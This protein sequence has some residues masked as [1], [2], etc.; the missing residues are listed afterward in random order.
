MTDLGTLSGDFSS[1]GEAIADN[2]EV[3]GLSCDMSGNCRAFLWQNGVM[4]DLNALISVSSPLFLIDVLGV[5]SRGEIVGD[6]LEISSGE[7]HA[8]L[9]TPRHGRAASEIAALAMRG[10][11]GKSPKVALPE[12][13][14]KALGKRLGRRYHIPLP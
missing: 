1:F 2:G 4:T 14:R 11:S 13:V 6:A 10:E 8:Y 9:A 5:N 12:N 3:G 7:V